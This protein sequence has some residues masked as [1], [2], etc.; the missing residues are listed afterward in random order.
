M[1]YLGNEKATKDIRKN[2]QVKELIENFD[3][4]VESAKKIGSNCWDAG[5][6]N[7]NL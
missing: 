5:S 7:Q 3:D 6:Q 2:E 4:F 1:R